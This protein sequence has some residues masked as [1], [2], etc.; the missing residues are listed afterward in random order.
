MTKTIFK[1]GDIVK[2]TRFTPPL[3]PFRENV[4]TIT[5]EKG[6]L[7][8]NCR[9]FR[10]N[11]GPFRKHL[12]KI[13]N[14][15]DK[16]INQKIQME[17]NEKVI[18]RKNTPTISS[19]EKNP[20][21][22]GTVKALEEIKEV[23][24]EHNLIWRL[25]CGT[26]LGAVRDKKILSWDCDIDT[27]MVREEININT[28]LDALNKLSDQGFEVCWFAD[29][30]MIT[31]RKKGSLHINIH[32]LRKKKDYLVFFQTKSLKKK[33]KITALLGWLLLAARD[34]IKKRRMIINTFIT[35]IRRHGGELQDSRIP[36]WFLKGFFNVVI[37]IFTFIPYKGKLI[38][39]LWEKVS[40]KDCR[41]IEW[42][43]LREHYSQLGKID[44]YGKEYHAPFNPEKH[45]EFVYGK[46]WRIPKKDWEDN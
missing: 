36:S 37:F 1:V 22:K 15:K 6:Y 44:F 33:T 17:L 35:L 28:L 9:I 7:W 34:G 14:I 8:L 25:D 31:F 19:K 38:Q 30:G 10:T 23:F 5:K 39:L 32:I 46:D 40:L 13:G 26:L 41:I 2:T 11:L 16:S 3:D 20:H 27:S 12:T 42:K 4:Y 21:E 29:R 45:L 43:F 24:E 18:S